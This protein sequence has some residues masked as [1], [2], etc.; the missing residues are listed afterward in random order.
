MSQPPLARVT[1]LPA[2]FESYLGEIER[3]WSQDADGEA[4]PFQIVRFGQGPAPGTITFATLGLSRHGMPSETSGRVIFHE[5]VMCVPEALRNGPLPSILQQ[6]G[7]DVLAT[8]RPLLRGEVVGPRGP[9]VPGS[10]LEALYAAAPVCFPDGFG[11]C[12]DADRSVAI[13]WLVPISLREARYVAEH[14][15]D[16]FEDRLVEAQPDLTDVC[17]TPLKF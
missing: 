1:D 10:S 15:W 9:L 3:G 7:L 2:H 13:A 5:F 8:A 4:V 11:Q 17:R 16:A 14:G 12:E 6:V